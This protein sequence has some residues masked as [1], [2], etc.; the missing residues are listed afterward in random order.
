MAVHSCFDFT[1][2]SRRGW[3]RSHVK[4]KQLIK[5]KGKSFVFLTTYHW[6]VKRKGRRLNFEKNGVNKLVGSWR[7]LPF[8]VSTP[9]LSPANPNG[10]TFRSR[11]WQRF[12]TSFLHRGKKKKRKEKKRKAMPKVIVKAQA[13]SLNSSLG[14]TEINK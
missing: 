6:N 11:D 13:S 3:R 14:K 12:F 4:K 2:T 7:P 1:F 8:G 9:T 10:Y 5:T